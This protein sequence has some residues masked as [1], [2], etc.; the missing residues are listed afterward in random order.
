MS[1]TTEK[2]EIGQL[3]AT[4]DKRSY[5]S[6]IADYDLKTG[7]CELVDNAVDQWIAAGRSRKLSVDL[8][9]DA[10]RQLITIRDTA[11]G[12]KEKDLRLLVAPGATKNSP[13]SQTIGIFGVGS[14]RAVIALAE[15]TNIKTR[16]ASSP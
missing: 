16:Y 10:E 6:I 1:R 9:L 5:W 7:I 15:T 8:S 3:D 4:P 2:R 13:D 14:K 12:V 11:G